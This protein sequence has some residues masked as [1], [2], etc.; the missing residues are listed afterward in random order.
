MAKKS[1]KL[2]E[3]NII[4][5]YK[6][7]DSNLSCRGFKFEVGKTYE[8]SG[9][10]VVC[11]NG[12][13]ACETPFDVLSYYGY[14][15]DKA[16]NKF[17]VVKQSGDIS[18]CDNDSKIAS[19]K[20]TIDCELSIPEFVQRGV[21]WILD[22]IE[23][24]KTEHNTGD[25][26]AATNTGYYS[27]A[28]NTGSR[29]AATNTGSQ[30]AATN[31]GYQSAATNTGNCGMSEVSGKQSIAISTSYMGRVK[32]GVDCD[33]V[34]REFDENGNR[35]SIACGTVGKKGI[36]ADTWYVCKNGKLVED[37]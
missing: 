29:S 30:S 4:V 32:G 37:K 25:Q 6:G 2:N 35:L 16:V 3:D 20:I 11:G 23:N 15:G 31:T 19:A 21:N 34:A 17:A 5:S 26:S 12:F 24:K 1:K 10:I 36:K 8:Q 18:H 27:A 13:H 9:E 22:H 7:F 28:T 14:C 33:L